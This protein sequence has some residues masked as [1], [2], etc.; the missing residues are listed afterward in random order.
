MDK[1]SRKDQKNGR[2]T[3]KERLPSLPEPTGETYPRQTPNTARESFGAPSNPHKTQPVNRHYDT[4]EPPANKTKTS[5]NLPATANERN[6]TSTTTTTT[7]NRVYTEIPVVSNINPEHTSQPGDQRN[8][9]GRDRA[10]S[11][12]P[13]YESIDSCL[14]PETM[15]LE[16]LP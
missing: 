3:R 13:T 14:S 16:V 5:L 8:D 11:N 2:K 10:N 9:V 1:T 6:T 4:L 12:N 15:Y 7:E